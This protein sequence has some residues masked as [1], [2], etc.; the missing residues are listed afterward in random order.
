VEWGSGLSLQGSNPELLMSALCQKPTFCAATD[1]A[2]RS[3]RQQAIASGWK[4]FPV[5][6]GTADD[7]VKVGLVAMLARPDGNITGVN[8]LAAA[9]YWEEPNQRNGR[10]N[11]RSSP[12]A[13][14]SHCESLRHNDLIDPVIRTV[15]RISGG[16]TT[17]LSSRNVG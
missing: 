11:P 15:T 3:P 1:T 9:R 8:F 12:R 17:E 16:V 2:I 14:I 13:R 10:R 4:R 7:L 5:V 6:F